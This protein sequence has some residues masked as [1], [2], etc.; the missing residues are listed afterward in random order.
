MSRARGKRPR[1]ATDRALA[2]LAAAEK[3]GRGRC[4]AVI[5][6]GLRAALVADDLVAPDRDGSLVVTAPGHA[7]LARL[8]AAS[9]GDDI[10]PFRRQHGGIARRAGDA[11][12]PAREPGALVND[13][14]SPLAWLARRKGRDGQ[15]LVTPAQFLAGERLRADF[16]FAQLAPRM[17][18]DWAS[19][20]IGGAGA[21]AGG[22][23]APAETV[24][25]ARQRL[26]RALAAVGPEFS[27]LLV[28]VCCF[29]KGLEDVERERGWPARSGK[30][31]LQL[32]LDRIARHYG[33]AVEARGYARAPLRTWLA[34]DAS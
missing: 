6:P 32:G 25:A 15:P 24:V 3:S 2:R 7:R 26:R 1:L 33:L 14:E 12:A 20:G 5:E 4:R 11:D 23:A 27:G 8:A 28:D 22:P 21:A 31:V 16:T 13:A 19:P 9:T 29:L 10:G 18:V 34:P 30:I 17:T